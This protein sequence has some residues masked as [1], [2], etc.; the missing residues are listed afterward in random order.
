[1]SPSM[2]FPEQSPVPTQGGGRVVPSQPSRSG[3]FRQGQQEVLG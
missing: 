3:S 1:M 2:K